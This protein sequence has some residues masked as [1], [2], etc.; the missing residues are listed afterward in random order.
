MAL[1]FLSYIAMLP[2]LTTAMS[3]APKVTCSAK[4]GWSPSSPAGYTSTFTLPFVLSETFLAKSCAASCGNT[5]KG[6]KG[7]GTKGS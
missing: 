5:G 6:R 7:G 3:M 1:S 2:R 4:A